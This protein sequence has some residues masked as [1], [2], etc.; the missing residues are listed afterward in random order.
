[1]SAVFLTILG[2]WLLLSILAQFSHFVW[3]RWLRDRD[4]LALIPTWSFFAPDPGIGDLQLFYRD[5]LFD[6]QFT[7]WEVVAFRNSSFLRV[8]W[9]P[10]KRRRKAIINACLLLL[11]IANNHSQR[12]MVFVTVPYR[13]ILMYIT[14]MPCSKLSHARQFLIA[15]T[16]GYYPTQK[17]EVLFVTQ[18]HE[19]KRVLC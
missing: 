16:F 5:K 1:M 7:H 18:I 8:I 15:Q 12:K 2:A 4:Y 11:Q 17:A 19:L 9:N 3:M 6:G 14:A 10:E 13:L